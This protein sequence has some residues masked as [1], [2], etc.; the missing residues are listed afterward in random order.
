MQTVVPQRKEIY[1]KLRGL[2]SLNMAV[3]KYH[4]TLRSQSTN[5]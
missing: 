3:F 2:P 4:K 1:A 5:E